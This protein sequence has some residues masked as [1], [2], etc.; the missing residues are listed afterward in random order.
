MV[1]FNIPVEPKGKQRAR[2]VTRNGK[3]IAYTPGQ[4][5]MTEN[6]IRAYIQREKVYFDKGTPIHL[7]VTFCLARPKSCPK[8]RVL[9]VTRPDLDNMTKLVLDAC[10]KFLWHDDSQITSLEVHKRYNQIP[11]IEMEIS[12][13]A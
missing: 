1:K 4:T 10:N 8:K 5:A 11:H 3:V 6:M 2:V 13:D 9:P 7:K 12:E